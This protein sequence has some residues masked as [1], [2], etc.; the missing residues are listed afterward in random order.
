MVLPPTEQI[1]LLTLSRCPASVRGELLQGADLAACREALREARCEVVLPCGAFAFVHPHLAGYVAE[2]LVP[3]MQASG[4][5][6]MGRHVICS[7]QFR[8]S[9]CSAVDHVRTRDHTRVK[10]VEKLEMKEPLPLLRVERTFLHYS[11]YS[12][13]VST[14]ST[15]VATIGLNP[16]VQALSPV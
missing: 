11:L 2:R 12:S 7:H 1:W 9:V 15:T 8:S 14:A 6:M 16:R 4:R 10:Q 5:R 13:R 3:A